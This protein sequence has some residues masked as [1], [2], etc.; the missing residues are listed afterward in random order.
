VTSGRKRDLMAH[1]LETEARG[2]TLVF[3]RTKHGAD[4]LARHLEG[5]GHAVALLHGNR[6][7]SQRT[8]ALDAFRGK[9]ARAMVATDIAGRRV[10]GRRGRG[11]Q[12]VRRT[13][14]RPASRSPRRRRRPAGP[15]RSGEDGAPGAWPER[16]HDPD[17]S[18]DTPAGIQTGRSGTERTVHECPAV[19]DLKH[20]A[21]ARAGDEAG[22][23]LGIDHQVRQVASRLQIR[24]PDRAARVPEDRRAVPS[25]RGG[26]PGERNAD[27][28]RAARA[29]TD[30]VAVMGHRL[31]PRSRVLTA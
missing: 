19:G 21:E 9:R 2:L 22:Q 23:P 4:K 10:P 29:E 3:T 13:A 18:N 17:V 27:A 25:V 14:P 7:Q 1:L 31:G 26:V 24:Y 5:R 12:T 8:R 30:T 6:S 28:R 20:L 15:A 11:A 16:H